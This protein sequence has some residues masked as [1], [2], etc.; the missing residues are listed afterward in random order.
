MTMKWKS[1]TKSQVINIH[2]V[3]VR[4][5][6]FVVRARGSHSGCC[7]EWAEGDWIEEGEH[8]EDGGSCSERHGGNTDM[9]MGHIQTDPVERF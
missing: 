4:D 9:V 1:R 5:L 2:V 6:E 3:Q 7:V 8:L